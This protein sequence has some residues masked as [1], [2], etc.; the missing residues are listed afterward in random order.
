MNQH[1]GVAEDSTQGALFPEK[2]KA[3]AAYREGEDGVWEVNV[4]SPKEN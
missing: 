4:C 3:R 1:R 2:R